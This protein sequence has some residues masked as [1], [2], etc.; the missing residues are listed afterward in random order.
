MNN[1][2]LSMVELVVVM[3][4]GAG[5]LFASMSTIMQMSRN[6]QTI[7]KRQ[8]VDDLN[9]DITAYLQ[10]PTRCSNGLGPTPLNFDNRVELQADNTQKQ[11]INIRNNSEIRNL[12]VDL[13]ELKDARIEVLYQFN[14]NYYSA[15]LHYS[16]REEGSNETFNAK[17][18][19]IPLAIYSQNGNTIDT[20]YAG[21]VDTLVA[22]RGDSIAPSTGPTPQQPTQQVTSVNCPN[23][24]VVTGIN[25]DGTVNCSSL[26]EPTIVAAQNP[27]PAPT[28]SSPPRGSSSGTV[29][30]GTVN[31]PGSSS[32]T[33]SGCNNSSNCTVGQASGT[34]SGVVQTVNTTVVNR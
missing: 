34:N 12:K 21:S 11:N 29:V 33:F 2:G 4:V 32:N 14:T 1:K 19:N 20:C 3:G 18:R 25:S 26:P 13:L 6:Y 28:N 7:K 5:L 31:N 8:S 24:E 15:K 9:F 23:G 10:D 30:S 17:E 22:L 27:A 16:V